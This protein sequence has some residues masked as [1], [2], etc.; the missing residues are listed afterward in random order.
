MNLYHFQILIFQSNYQ[1]QIWKADHLHNSCFEEH[2]I[3]QKL[4]LKKGNQHKCKRFI[5]SQ[6]NNILLAREQDQTLILFPLLF[7][8][9]PHKFLFL[10]EILLL[11]LNILTELN[12]L[13]DLPAVLK[14]ASPNPYRNLNNIQTI[15]NVV[16]CN[17]YLKIN[18][19]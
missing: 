18:T 4:K 12:V 8:N 3:T 14:Q 17:C 16:L 19:H 13:Q 2:S 7:D 9:N 6:Q 11:I 15:K 5:R 10:W 1:S